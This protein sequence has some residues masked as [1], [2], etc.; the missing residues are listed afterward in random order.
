MRLSLRFDDEREEQRFLALNRQEQAR[1]FWKVIVVGLGISFAFLWQ[2]QLINPSFGYIASN[3]RIYALGPVCGLAIWIL[4]SKRLPPPLIEPFVAV[5]YLYYALCTVAIEIVFEGTDYGLSSSVGSGS[6]LLLV[7]AAFT[8][9]YLRFWWS[10]A[11]GVIVLIMYASGMY[12]FS[13]KSF[14]DFLVGDFLTSVA[15]GVVGAST[16]LFRERALREQFRASESISRE[17]EQYRS[18]LYMLVPGAIAERI[19][20]GE[21]PIAESHAEVTIL[22]ADLVGFTSLTRTR[23]PREIVQILNELF[24]TFDEVAAR[25]EVE[26]IKTIGDGYMAICGPPVNEDKRAPAVARLA[27]QMAI[28]HLTDHR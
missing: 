22:F 26:K 9:S 7:L 19:Q 10:L 8:F 3:I 18:L 20:A 24:Q 23:A 11:V 6:F 27:Q 14:G 5:V 1:Y 13:A 4:I 15:A 28:M 21:F 16:S 2:D 17:R 25:L 12:W